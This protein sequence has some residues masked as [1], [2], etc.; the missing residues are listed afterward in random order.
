MLYVT[1]NSLFSFPF[2]YYLYELEM[3]EGF[4]SFTFL[5][6]IFNK[7]YSADYTCILSLQ[8]LKLEFEEMMDDS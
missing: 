4:I 1:A 7:F 3:G 6:S 2:H 8:Y 5:F